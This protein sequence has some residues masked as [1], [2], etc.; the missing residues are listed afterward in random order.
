MLLFQLNG[1]RGVLSIC[2]T[3]PHLSVG[4]SAATF[5]QIRVQTMR[6]A[7]NAFNATSKKR[8]SFCV[9]KNLSLEIINNV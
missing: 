6:Y 9:R 7:F 4:P 2:F 8:P 3:V 1:G 5:H